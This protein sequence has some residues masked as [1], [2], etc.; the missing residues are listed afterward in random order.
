[1]VAM[2]WCFWTLGGQSDR[3]LRDVAARVCGRRCV[4]VR[5]DLDRVY[6]ASTVTGD[7]NQEYGCASIRA[8]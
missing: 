5:A 4:G 2:S 8:H 6:M 7:Q 1:M 3:D